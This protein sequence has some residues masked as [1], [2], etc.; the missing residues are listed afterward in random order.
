MHIFFDYA[1]FIWTKKI[2]PTHFHVFVVMSTN[3]YK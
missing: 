1:L 3:F 2:N